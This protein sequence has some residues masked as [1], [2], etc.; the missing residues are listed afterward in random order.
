MGPPGDL[1]SL[2]EAERLAGVIPR[3][4]R[5]LA[6]RHEA[7]QLASEA[8]LGQGRRPR[9]AYLVAQRGGG[10]RWLVRR[11]ELAAYLARRRPPAVRVGYDPTLT[12]EKSLGVL[13]LLAGDPTRRGVLAAIRAGNDW[14]LDWLE[15]H[16]AVTRANGQ[17]VPARGWTVASFRHLTS[18][19]NVRV[20]RLP[21]ASV[22]R[23]GWM[24]D[25]A[26]PGR[27]EES[28]DRLL[29]EV[30]GESAAR[31]AA[32]RSSQALEGDRQPFRHSVV[33]T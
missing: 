12:T 16:A 26:S 15:H 30:Q 25:Q 24:A 31:K 23:S 17:P 3:Y 1:L 28:E 7:R 19:A 18:R 27:F 13:A 9:Q 32:C 4:L 29:G 14:A 21:P 11:D 33:T 2:G 22:P 10:A 8:A 20:V 6:Q 5:R